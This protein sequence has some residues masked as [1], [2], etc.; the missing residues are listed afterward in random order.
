MFIFLIGS[1]FGSFL[2]VMAQRVPLKQSFVFSRSKCDHCQ[3]A[4]R[5]WEMIPIFS[6]L[7]LRFRCRRCGQRFSRLLFLSEIIYGGILTFCWLQPTRIEQGI[8]LIWLTTLFLLSLTDLFYLTVEPK[9]LY[10]GHGLLWGVCFYTQQPFY[11][12]TIGMLLFIGFIY[13][14]YLKNSMG[15][16]DLLLLTCWAP[17]LTPSDFSLMLLTA[18]I[19]ALMVFGGCFLLKRSLKQL[20]FVP[21]LSLGV[22]LVY[23]L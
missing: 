17:W 22:F 19:L 4:L 21:F 14:A 16:G 15:L 13:L 5:F 18:S 10:I 1:I 7:F 23:F 3:Q 12:E 6:S 20:P 11:W 8:A 9:I 2:C